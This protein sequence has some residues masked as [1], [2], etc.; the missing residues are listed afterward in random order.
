MSRAM[1]RAA[2]AAALFA[3]VAA[4]VYP[5]DEPAVIG[6]AARPALVRVAS[7]QGAA[8]VATADPAVAPET[9]SRQTR[10]SAGLVAEPGSPSAAPGAAPQARGSLQAS[11]TLDLSKLGR[12]P[13]VIEGGNPFVLPPP[14]PPPAPRV[15]K[16]TAPPPPPPQQAPPLPFRMIGS[17]NEDGKV[18]IFAARDNGDVV[19]LRVAD[20][21]D[22]TYR[23]DSINNQQMTL[24][25]L[26]LNQKQ[27]L[28]VG[29]TQ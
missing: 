6:P 2:L 18:T 24:T 22:N 19:S 9:A 12:K 21:V 16:A 3:T 27:T 14:P 28:P 8:A 15:R 11:S 7:V 29:P 26:P 25:Y 5:T 13:S 10:A 17:I 20:I 23:V 1:L 4:A